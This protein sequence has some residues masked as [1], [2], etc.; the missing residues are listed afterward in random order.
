MTDEHDFNVI[1][2]DGDP[3]EVLLTDQDVYAIHQYRSGGQ[4]RL[5]M[6]FE[7][8]AETLRAA[9]RHATRLVESDSASEYGPREFHAASPGERYLDEGDWYLRKHHG[10]GI[11]HALDLDDDF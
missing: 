8:D 6:I 5:V 2:D 9:I 10:V 4:D 11:S 7:D 1:V 3:A